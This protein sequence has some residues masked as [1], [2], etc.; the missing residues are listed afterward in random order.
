MSD[1][2]RDASRA[3]AREKRAAD[4]FYDVIDPTMGRFVTYRSHTGDGVESPAQVLRSSNTL[5]IKSQISPRDGCLGVDLIR[6][7]FSNRTPATL[8][9]LHCDLL[10]HGLHRDYRVY[11][12]PYAPAIEGASACSWHWPSR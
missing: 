6:D 11:N 7:A 9:R 2:P 10:V 12:V 3:I 1:G 4:Q 5:V 8:V